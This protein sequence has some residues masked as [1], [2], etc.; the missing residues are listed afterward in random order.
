MGCVGWYF[1]AHIKPIIISQL[2]QQLNVKVSVKDIK[3]SKLSAFPKLG[4]RFTDVVIEESASYYKNPLLNAKELNL[5][6]NIYKLLNKEYVVDAI[7]VHNATIR[8]ADLESASN[9]DIFKTDSS[10]TEAVDFEIENLKIENCHIIYTHT[11]SSFLAEAQIFNAKTKLSYK[12]ETTDLKIR[13]NFLAKRILHDNNFYLK[14]QSVNI[15]TQLIL[16]NNNTHL[17][18]SPSDMIIEEVALKTKGYIKL[19]ESTFISLNFSNQQA[20]LQSIF[21]ILPD[22]IQDATKHIEA[23]GNATIE[24]YFKGSIDEKNNPSFGFTYTLSDASLSP[25][26]QNISI[27]QLNAGGELNIRD[28]G[29]LSSAWVKCHIKGAQS[30]K[31]QINGDLF[32]ENFDNPFV[33]WSGSAALDAPTIAAL[34]HSPNYTV[35]SGSFAVDGKFE[36]IYLIDKEEVKP[37]SFKFI[38]DIKGQN[39]VMKMNDP[40]LDVK[41]FNFDFKANTQHM[42]INECSINYNN[43]RV[44]LIGIVRNL[45]ELFSNNSST[46]I[47]GKLLAENL[48]IN[49]FISSDTSHG[50]SA[51]S[52]EIF[53]YH[54]ALETNINNFIYNNFSAK[55]LSGTLRSDRKMFEMQNCQMQALEGTAEANIKFTTLGDYYLLDVSSRVRGINITELFRQFN[56]FDQTEITDQHLSGS[57]SGTILAKVMF[58]ANFEPVFDKLYAKADIEVLN[59]ELNGYEPLKELSDFVEVED[60]ENVKFSSLRNTIEIF[61][62]TIF[63]PKMYIGNNA[64]NIELEGTHSFENYMNYSMSISLAELLAKRSNW[65]AKKKDQRIEDNEYGGLTAFIHMEGTPENLKITYDKIAVKRVVQDELQKEKKKFFNAIQGKTESDQRST[66]Y[67]QEEVWDE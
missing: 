2:N 42:V 47:S 27:N 29:D 43:S 64:M 14:N 50:S 44:E 57:L 52:K 4:I 25:Q 53:P 39:I 54:L 35:K 36:F 6:I 61:D 51:V 46:E 19:E 65:I 21:S 1:S 17:S 41:A 59:G 22:Y 23:S 30:G 37:N 56:N 40:A 67:Y 15:N 62:Q 48:D 28:L 33:K 3:I 20:P 11:G 9:Y 34:I 8:L 10:S 55:T 5:Y 12:D 16:S 63:I 7:T 49:E 58:D 31:N 45:D 38:G 32:I 60:L 26:Y 13:G 18:I 24:G 66:E